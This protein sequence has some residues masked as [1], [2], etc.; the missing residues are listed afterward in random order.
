MADINTE[1]DSLK[2][3]MA[4][5]IQP[6]LLGEDFQDTIYKVANYASLMAPLLDMPDDVD[7]NIDIK[8]YIN[9]QTPGYFS[10]KGE[11]KTMKLRIQ[12]LVSN[13]AKLKEALI[14]AKGG[15]TASSTTHSSLKLPRLQIPQFQDNA[16][17]TVNWNNFYEILERLTDGM[18][19][20]EKNL[21]L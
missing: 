12:R 9:D 21:S 11:I 10:L 4:D 18:N 1:L 8:D 20:G 13:E 5:Q 14:Q 17:G 6:S 3:A 19:P 7:I 16:S 2:E 15:A